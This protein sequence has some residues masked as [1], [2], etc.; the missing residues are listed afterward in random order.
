[1]YICIY[2]YIV[3]DNDD[4]KKRKCEK[5]KTLRF[6]KSMLTFQGGE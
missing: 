2:R 1:M 4:E 3:L 5:K 6:D